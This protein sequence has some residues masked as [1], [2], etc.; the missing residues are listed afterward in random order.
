MAAAPDKQVA[1]NAK[2]LYA[3]KA[4]YLVSLLL[5]KEMLAI[6]SKN[7][8]LS[9]FKDVIA[10]YSNPAM[11]EVQIALQLHPT[12]FN[13][14]HLF[15]QS[16]NASISEALNHILLGQELT[17]ELQEADENYIKDKASLIM[18]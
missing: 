12:S 7:L 6:Y 14:G 10:E 9:A 18:D 5:D 1:I 3:V 8:A 15:T 11:K 2:T 4:K 16:A 13:P 17:N